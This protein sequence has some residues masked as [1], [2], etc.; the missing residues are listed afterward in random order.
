MRVLL[1]EDEPR[2]CSR[3]G[4]A[5]SRT[6]DVARDGRHALYWPR[7]PSATPSCWMS[8]CRASMDSKCARSCGALAHVPVLMLT[9]RDAIESRIAGLDSGADDYLIKPFDFGELLARLRAVIRRGRLP[10]TPRCSP[11]ATCASTSAR[12]RPAA[13]ISQSI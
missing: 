8:C 1:V 4:C 9:A 2:N 7:S 5:S 10:V 13:T 3:R 6:V 11:S 12:A